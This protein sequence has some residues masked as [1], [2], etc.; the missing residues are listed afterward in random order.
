MFCF[1]GSD[2]KEGTVLIEHLTFMF[3]CLRGGLN[4]PSTPTKNLHG[5]GLHSSCMGEEG[6]K[7]NALVTT[8]FFFLLSSPFS[9]V[10]SPSK[11]Q[12]S[13]SLF[14]VPPS[15][16]S[17]RRHRWLLPFAYWSF[18]C[19]STISLSLNPL[20][21][22]HFPIPKK[23]HFFPRKMMALQVFMNDLLDDHH[24]RLHQQQ[25]R[26]QQQPGSDDQTSKIE[27][28]TE[29]NSSNSSSSTT[30][31]TTTTNE[32]AT[33]IVRNELD[34]KIVNDNAQLLNSPSLLFP[35]KT[36]KT[37]SCI[38]GDTLLY[39]R[40]RGGGRKTIRRTSPQQ[41]LRKQRRQLQQQQRHRNSRN[42]DGDYDNDD[43]DYSSSSSSYDEDCG[44]YKR[45]RSSPNNNNH[46]NS[47]VV[48]PIE[49]I[50]K[51][52]TN[53]WDA[54]SPTG[55]S[56]RGDGGGNL[57]LWRQESDSCLVKPKRNTNFLPFLSSPP[58]PPPPSKKA[59]ASSSPW[60]LKKRQHQ[61][62]QPPSG[63]IRPTFLLEKQYSDS[64]LIIPKRTLS[65]PKK[66]KLQIQQQQLPSPTHAKDDDGNRNN[67]RPTM[68]NGLIFRT[69]V[70]IN[71]KQKMLSMVSPPTLYRNN[72]DID[73]N[74]GIIATSLS[75]TTD[76]ENE[77]GED[78][79]T[80]HLQQQLEPQQD[81]DVNVNV[82]VDGPDSSTITTTTSTTNTTTTSIGSSSMSFGNSNAN[83][84]RDI[85]IA[86]RQRKRLFPPPTIIETVK[87]EDDDD[88]L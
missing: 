38:G 1:S 27:I 59:P 16:E 12:A 84:H 80:K 36:K 69:R 62:Q 29:S 11:W 18:Q 23:N 3:F 41:L 49:D 66:V 63:P 55:C 13:Q 15:N 48:I 37:I 43:G 56:R 20:L 74:D 79:K 86:I 71:D 60:T 76:S 53:R 64:A 54:T 47:M 31:T 5:S 35:R 21:S 61:H 52:I 73:E 28:F 6:P 39:N 87:E 82:V 88:Y 83:S 70:V 34:I 50:G 17:R 4:H 40:L 67:R 78:D 44:I 22:F 81:L 77:D 45:N 10:I 9:F 65:P 19:L 25:R 72:N 2:K 26:R 24:H 14:V 33:M 85:M 7:H 30:T 32:S 58:P 8:Y 51:T 42:N 68:G 75:T 57:L 46:N